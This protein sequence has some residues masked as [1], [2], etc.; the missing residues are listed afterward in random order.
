MLNGKPTPPPV[1]GTKPTPP[2]VPGAKPTPPL[3]P[4]EKKHPNLGFVIALVILGLL[5]VVS[6]A[7]AYWTTTQSQKLTTDLVDVRANL[8]ETQV[9]LEASE[10]LI[11]AQ[12]PFFYDTHVNFLQTSIHMID[13]V[14]GKDEIIF[15]VDDAHYIV[16]AI[17]RI[18][19]DGRIFL[20]SVGE[21]DDP[22]LALF[23]LDVESKQ[24]TES[25]INK[26]LPFT[27]KF[28][29]LLS[30][31]ETRLAAAYD[32]PGYDD[33]AKELLVWNLLT[34]EFE[35]IGTIAE[36]EYFPNIQ[37]NAFAGA[38]GYELEWKDLNC[39][40]TVIHVDIPDAEDTTQKKF[41]EYRTF[42]EK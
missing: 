30:S 25:S 15:E 11:K 26:K 39:V 22:G 3:V 33:R 18:S 1:P 23:E 35:V 13:P 9:K 2:P 7:F 16:F 36:V 24:I 42:C 31:D 41:K 32:N 12:I 6:A 27:G 5:F 34:G 4:T 10:A 29:T 40:Q 38:E 19:Y 28:S 21:G 37:G 17:P 8:A 14:S 20:S